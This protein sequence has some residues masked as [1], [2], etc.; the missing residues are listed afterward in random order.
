ML[1]LEPPAIEKLRGDLARISVVAAVAGVV[2]LAFAFAWSRSA[3]RLRAVERQTAQ[4]Q[5]LVAL[6]SMSSVMA[7]ELRNPLASLKGHAQL[8]VEDLEEGK[9]KTK[10]GTVSH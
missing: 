9:N 3:A 6:G 5:R 7:H 2:L 8:L 10:A 4:E 1:E